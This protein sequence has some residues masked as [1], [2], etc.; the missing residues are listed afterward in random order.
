MP[1]EF[2]WDSRSLPFGRGDKRVEK[3]LARALRLAGSAA[4]RQVQD[5]SVE[6]VTTKKLISADTVRDGLPLDLPG[7]KVEISDLQWTERISGKGMALVRFPY[8]QTAL[9]ARVRVNARSGFKLLKGSF[10]LRLRSGHVGIFRREG[11]ARLPIKELWTTRI[12]DSMSDPGAVDGIGTKAME[13]LQTAFARGLE[14]EL[15]KLRRKG[16]A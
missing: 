7:T 15:A 2:E 10:T 11:A 1:I 4:I 8:M 13:K 16:D 9:G 12:S 5:G 6:H 14:R 3:A